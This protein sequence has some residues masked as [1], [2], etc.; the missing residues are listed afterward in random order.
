MTGK[1]RLP[2]VGQPDPD[3]PTDIH[4][5]GRYAVGVTWADR[6]GSIYPFEKLRRDCACGA[7]ATLDVVTQAMAWPTGITRTP[8]GLRVVWSD[9]HESLYAYP[10]LRS[11]C[12]CAAC[13]GGH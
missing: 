3:T 7:C 4:L 1:G 9:Q 12:R 13:T 11:M 10:R 6:H 8:A 2:I 5:V